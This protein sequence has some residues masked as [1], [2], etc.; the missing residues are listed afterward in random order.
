V[1][2]PHERD[3]HEIEEP[4]DLIDVL[5]KVVLLWKD[6]NKDEMLKTLK[7]SRWGDKDAFYRVAQA[8]SE[9]LPDES[10]E[11]KYL[12]GFLT[13]KDQL[14]SEIKIPRAEQGELKF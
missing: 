4:V 6:G 14:I 1:L 9:T 13:G 10:R 11:K 2:G 5:H 12:Q 8:I 3:L 7:N